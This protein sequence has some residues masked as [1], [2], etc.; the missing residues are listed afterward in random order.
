MIL[1]SGGRMDKISVIIPIYNSEKYIKDCILSVLDQSYQNLEIIIVDDG[2]KDKSCEI[3]EELLHTSNINYKIIHQENQGV[4]AARNRGIESATG[5]WIIAIDSD[6]R[7]H[8]DT[9]KIIMENIG[10]AD[11]AMFDFEINGTDRLTAIQKR[12]ISVLSGKDAIEGF[13]NRKYKFIAPAS[14]IRKNF[15][16]ENRIEYDETCKF[17]ED[18]L[19]VWKVLCKA[20]KVLYIKSPLYIY[21][22]HDNSTMT[23]P[24]ISKFMSAKEASIEVSTDFVKKSANAEHIKEE[25]LYRH[26]LGI[27]H[28]AAK[29]HS[30]K[31]FS[32]LIDYFELPRIYREIHGKIS[33]GVRTKFNLILIAPKIVYRLFRAI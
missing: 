13:Y 28:A 27:L 31:E 9:F 3:V 2:S 20:N 22:F 26:Y 24:N 23:T 18:D 4:A 5:S 11:A 17:A 14:L 6:D 16:L 33:F 32:L 29:V 1:S 15:L 30:Q 10:E 7:I 25:F 21:I 12:D 19:Y 8:K